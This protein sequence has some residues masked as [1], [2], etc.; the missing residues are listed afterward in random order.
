MIMLCLGKRPWLFLALFLLSGCV[1]D[2]W[3]RYADEDYGPSRANQICHPYADC[4]QG[5]WIATAQA[6]MDSHQAYLVC[7]EQT[8]QRHDEWSESTVSMGLEVG[9]CMRSLG[10]ELRRQ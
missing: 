8:R 2:I 6:E 10:Y 7:R 9:R 3:D 4:S 5:T 1:E